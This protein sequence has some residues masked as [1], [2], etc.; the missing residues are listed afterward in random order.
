MKVRE[1]TNNNAAKLLATK[2]RKTDVDSLEL[3]KTHFEMGRFLGYQVLEEFQL[4]KIDINHVQGIKTGFELSDENSVIIFGLMRAGLYVAEGLRS[5][6]SKCQF[7]LGENFETDKINLNNK[8]VIVA[9]AVINTGR[10]IERIIQQL[11]D[12]NVKRVFIVTLVMQ[13]EAMFLSD[14]YPN[15]FFYALRVSDNKYV[16]KGTTDTGNR[17]FNTFDFG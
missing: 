12:T 8:I 16:G 5:I 10:S 3:C 9:D 11:Q 6:F 2:S 1:Y 7:L 14:K 13:K 15:I 4:T 17:L